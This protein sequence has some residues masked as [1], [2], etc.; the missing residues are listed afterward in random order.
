MKL[1]ARK[2]CSFAGEKFFIGDQV[3]V[4]YVLDPQG[5]EKMGT[6]A[7][8]NDDA[9]APA[10]DESAEARPAVATMELVIHAEEGDLPLNL[11][12][13]GLQAVV[14]VLTD[15]VE[16]AEPI[17]GAMTDG[18]ALILLHCVDNRKG[19]KAAAEARAQ[20]LNAEE[21]EGEQ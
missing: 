13:E 4:E 6:L 18:D 3:P 15:T 8:V 7:I 20:A 21:S 16:G 9:G 12:A 2:P 5:Q 14:D 1:I 17:V 11:T 10:P 19:I